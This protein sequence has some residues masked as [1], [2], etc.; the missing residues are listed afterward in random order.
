[1]VLATLRYHVARPGASDWAAEQ[2][3][4]WLDRT[5]IDGGDPTQHQRSPHF[6]RPERRFRPDREANPEQREA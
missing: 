5:P 2:I 1:M 6:G 3:V 4:E